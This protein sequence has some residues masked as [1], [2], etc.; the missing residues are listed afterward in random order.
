MDQNTTASRSCPV[1]GSTDYVF[2]GRK[3]VEPEPGQEAALET[4]YAYRACG[5]EWRV[6]WPK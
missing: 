2:G 5:H 1:C 6:R 4:R 3:R